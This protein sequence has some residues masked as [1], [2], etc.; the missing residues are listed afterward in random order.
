MCVCVCVSGSPAQTHPLC[1]QLQYFITRVYP[2]MLWLFANCHGLTICQ[3]SRGG[4]NH[5][6]SHTHTM[7]IEG[8]RASKGVGGGSVY[9]AAVLWCTDTTETHTFSH[10][11]THTQRPPCSDLWWIGCTPAVTDERWM[12]S[13]EDEGKKGTG[14]GG[15][16]FNVCVR[17]LWRR[18]KRA[19]QSGLSAREDLTQ[20]QA[21]HFLLGSTCHFL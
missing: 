7:I 5:L 12:E 18:K 9:A 14:V 4:A 16:C 11:H 8:G 10:S 13:W 2:S 21:D 20:G 1:T 17:V 3:Q 19:E 15:D 6:L